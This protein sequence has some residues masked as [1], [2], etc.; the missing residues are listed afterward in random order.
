MKGLSCSCL[1]V[2]AALALVPL[3]GCG[4]SD[5]D[6]SGNGG[7]AG[8][9]AGSGGSNAGSSGSGGKA[10]SGCQVDTSY[11]PTID[12]ENFVTAVDNP[13]W[14]L[15]V[16]TKMVFEGHEHVEVTVTDQTK[17]ILGIPTIVVRDTV[18]DDM[19]EMVEDTFDWYAQDSDGNVWYMGED[20]KEYSGGMVSSTFGSWEAGVDGA[21]P[22]IVMHA[23][24][25]PV[26]EPYRQE[27]YACQAEDFAELKSTGETVTVPYGTFEN[28]LRT[29]EY[30]PLE[31]D[32]DEDKFYCPGVGFVK[33]IDNANGDLLELSEVVMP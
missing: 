26:D 17:T 1:A 32:L 11:N 5:N 8:T 4:S 20:T 22:G 13:L 27:Y 6:D 12:P 25:P 31:P 19:G 16:G 15:P 9:S 14:P 10:G 29:H 30:T 23:T 18:L 3:S 2:L 28:C 7:G 24:Q 21:K 33:E